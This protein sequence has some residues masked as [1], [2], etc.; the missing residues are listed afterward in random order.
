M[1]HPGRSCGAAVEQ[2]GAAKSREANEGKSSS[3]DIY[4][5][6]GRDWC[7]LFRF[8]AFNYSSFLITNSKLNIVLGPALTGGRRRQYSPSWPSLPAATRI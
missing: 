2:R 5:D 4:L 6:M 8:S 1:N 7:A 3:C